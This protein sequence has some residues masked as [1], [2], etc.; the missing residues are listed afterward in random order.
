[1]SVPIKLRDDF[2]AADVRAHARRCRD[3]AQVRRLLAIATILDGGSRSDAAVIGGVTRQIVRD[4]VLRFNAEGPEGL[5][6]RKAPGPQ[7]ILDDGH[8]RAL[9][10]IIEAG[11][12]PAAHGVVRWRI[13]DLAQWLW[14]EF[15]VSI[16]KQALGHELRAMGYRKLS[17]R[18]RHHGQRLEDIA[19]FKKSSPPVLAQITRRLPKGTPVELWWQDEAR[20]GQQT[21]LTR[22]WA[23]RGTRPCAPKDQ[24][25]SS[26]WIFGAICPAEGKAAGIVMPRCNSEAMSM[27]LEEIAFHVAPGAHAV[28]LLDQAGWHGSAELV[29]PQNIT[30]MPLPPRCPELNP[31]E[32]VWQFMRDNWL[33]NR[34]FSSYDDIVDHSCFAW[35]KLADQPWRIM[36]LGLRTWAHR[37]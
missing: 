2:S 32:N 31:V 14:D 1:M 29:V 15:K 30:L 3:G 34:I 28:V 26:A 24:R 8:R 19:V 6:T 4:W 20:I 16:S 33:S 9:E 27:H 37:F 35:N 18:P 21:K 11:P 22:R 7:T 23:R 10:E 5:A 36:T 25:R 12:I 13:I 17:A